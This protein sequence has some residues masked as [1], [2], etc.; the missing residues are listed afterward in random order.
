VLR[1]FAMR[2]GVSSSWRSLGMAQEFPRS[3]E[4]VG[5]VTYQTDRKELAEINE[6]LY[7]CRN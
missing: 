5:S 6:H 3:E 1:T 4:K 7:G 2:F